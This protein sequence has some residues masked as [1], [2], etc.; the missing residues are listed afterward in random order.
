M[1]AR[2]VVHEELRA[3]LQSRCDQPGSLAESDA[4]VAVGLTSLDVHQVAV[5]VRARIGL[6]PSHDSIAVADLRAV[7]DLVRTFQVAQRGENGGLA[8][9]DAFQLVAVRAERRRSM[10]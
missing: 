9:S 7:G 3:Q 2:Q 1:N 4:L 6:L 5:R 10:E 8:K